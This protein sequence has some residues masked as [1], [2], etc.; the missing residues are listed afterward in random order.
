MMDFYRQI[1][2]RYGMIITYPGGIKLPPRS[3]QVKTELTLHEAGTVYLLLS[4]A[5]ETYA[6]S[7]GEGENV[8]AGARVATLGDETPVYA[9]VAGKVIGVFEREGMHYVAIEQ[10]TELS[11]EVRTVREPESKK[12]AE[13]TGEE[14]LDAVRLLGV[15][16]TWSGDYLWRRASRS[17]QTTR[18]IVIDTTDD[19]AWSCTGYR[20]ALKHPGDVLSGAKILLH[21]LGASRIVLLVD[22]ERKKLFDAFDVLINDPK[23]TVIAQFDVKYPMCDQ[24]IYQSVYVRHLPKDH[25]AQDEGVF[26]VRAQTAVR[27]YQ[28]ILSGK[29]Q[30]MHTLTAAGEGFGKN[31]LMHVPIGTTWDKIL[32]CVQFK[33][34]SYVTRVGSLLGTE[35]AVGVPDGKTEAVFADVPCERE[36]MHCIACGRCAEVCPMRLEPYRILRTKNIKTA[37]ILRNNCIG[38]G[39]CNYICPANIALKERILSMQ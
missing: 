20:T 4:G 14:L 33:G 38:C 12:L 24:T 23:L 18:R 13:M 39:C 15:W 10:D 25:T 7:V 31:V 6:L 17:M 36:E 2:L 11:T 29:P 1:D 30:T 37:Q 27:L 21:M 19:S 8:L 5:E 9:S 16:D 26:I 28:S 3:E 32:K 22:A 35:T 34:G